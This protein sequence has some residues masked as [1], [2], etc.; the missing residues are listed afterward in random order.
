LIAGKFLWLASWG[1]R[2]RKRHPK[3]GWFFGL[4]MTRLEQTTPFHMMFKPIKK[5]GGNFSL[6]SIILDTWINVVAANVRK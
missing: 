4:N 3:T 1:S 2:I 5:C 6:P